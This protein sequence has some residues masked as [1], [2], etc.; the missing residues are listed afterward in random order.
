[1]INEGYFLALLTKTGL[2][3]WWKAELGLTSQSTIFW[4]YWDC[5]SFTRLKM[6]DTFQSCWD[7]ASKFVDFYQTQD[8]WHFNDVETLPLNLLDFNQTQDELHFSYVE[9]LP[10]NQLDFY[11]NNFPK[12]N[13]TFQSCWNAA[14][15]SVGLLPVLR[16]MTFQSCWDIA[17]KSVDFYQFQ[18]ELHFSHAEMLPLCQLDFYQTKDE[19]NFSHVEKLPLN[20]LDFYQSQDEWHF[21]HVETLPLH[22]LT[23]TRP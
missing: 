21:S 23:F 7:A 1:M 9:M 19:W 3:S 17:S 5:W 11:Q 10:L 6:N 18:D 16:W 22:L 2:E 8:E 12:M 14:S 20:Q 15:Q 4:S 13:D